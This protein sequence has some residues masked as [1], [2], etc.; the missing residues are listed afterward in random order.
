ME[1]ENFDIRVHASQNV[2]LYIL[3]NYFMKQTSYKLLI[4]CKVAG[5]KLY[6]ALENVYNN[7]Y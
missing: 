6:L 1:T 7:T 2:Y 5:N 3:H 4:L